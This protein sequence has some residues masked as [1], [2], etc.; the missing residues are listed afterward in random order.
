MIERAGSREQAEIVR[1]R[2]RQA[3]PRFYWLS[4]PRELRLC[5][6]IRRVSQVT[7]LDRF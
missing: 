3:E 6:D 4:E 7:T 2:D 5:V 1:G